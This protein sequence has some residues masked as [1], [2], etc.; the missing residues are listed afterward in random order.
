MDQEVRRPPKQITTH[1][2]PQPVV[3]WI[4]SRRDAD[5]AFSGHPQSS[6]PLRVEAHFA[7]SSMLVKLPDP[8]HA[9]A[10]LKADW[11][12]T[13][14]ESLLDSGESGCPGSDDERPSLGRNR[15][16]HVLAQDERGA[17][18]TLCQ[19]LTTLW[20]EYEMLRIQEPAEQFRPAF[21]FSRRLP[22]RRWGARVI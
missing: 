21:A 17:T 10:R 1:V 16:R 4:R 19:S 22:A 13:G 20:L 9:R 6:T 3:D 11:F 12:E 18:D 2:C 15:V 5:L 7:W 14:F 8:A